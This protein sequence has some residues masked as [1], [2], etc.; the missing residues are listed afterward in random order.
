MLYEG[1]EG[2]S[3]A[4]NFNLAQESRL[5]LRLRLQ[6]REITIRF[7]YSYNYFLPPPGE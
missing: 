6:E 7:S 3:D 4:A 5:R 2:I 1:E